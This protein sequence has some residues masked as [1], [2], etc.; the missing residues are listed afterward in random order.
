MTDGD[1]E[2]IALYD[3]RAAEYARLFTGKKSD[4][5]L[6]A[7]LDLVTPGG[8]VLDLG[9]GVANAAAQMRDSGFDVLALDA[10]QGMADEAK[11]LHN[12]DVR[13]GTF[14][15]ISSLGQ[16][17]GVWAHFSLLHADP[18]KFDG[19]ITD[20]HTALKPGAPFLIGMKTGDGTKRDTLGRRYTYRTEDA[21]TDVL[22]RT[23]FTV[24][25]SDTGAEEGFDGVIAPWVILVARA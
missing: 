17:D 16:F 13:I 19:H 3:E 20:L 15:D 21:L 10:S 9:C 18:D 5:R 24:V 25:T 8:R 12:I 23:G 11:R 4:P 14:E 22:T 7:F 6:V 2:T 1:R